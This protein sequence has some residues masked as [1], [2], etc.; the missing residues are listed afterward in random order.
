M[1][2]EQGSH[3]NEWR[4]EVSEMYQGVVGTGVNWQAR[5]LSEGSVSAEF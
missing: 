2:P 3:I 1:L 4:S 5:V